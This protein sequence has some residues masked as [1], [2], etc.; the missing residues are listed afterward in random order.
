MLLQGKFLKV[1]E[2]NILLMITEEAEAT[3]LQ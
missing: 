2:S 3:V 1:H